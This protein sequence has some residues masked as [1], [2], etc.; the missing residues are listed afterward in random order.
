MRVRARNIVLLI[1][2]K[3]HILLYSFQ[4]K[5]PPAIQKIISAEG[6]NVSPVSI[7]KFLKFYNKTDCL[8]QKDGSGQPT[9]LMPAVKLVVEQQRVKNDETIVFQLHKLLVEKSINISNTTILC[10]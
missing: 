5:H 8:S 4:G 6:I 3:Q 7:W 10:C 9:Q 2:A 1:Y